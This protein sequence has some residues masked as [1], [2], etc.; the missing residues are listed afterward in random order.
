LFPL[1]HIGSFLDTITEEQRV[2]AR[3]ETLLR[4]AKQNGIDFWADEDCTRRIV[5]F[6]DRAAQVREFRDFFGSTLSMIYNA[7]F[8]RNPQ[9]ANLTEPMDKFKDVESI[10]DFVKA[11]MVAGANFA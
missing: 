4:L 5:R 10:D 8:P 11:Q 1:L 2:N 6:Q 7:L 3:V 9:P